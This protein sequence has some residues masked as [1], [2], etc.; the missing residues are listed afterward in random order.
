MKRGQGV[1]SV[2]L[3]LVMLSITG[4]F[5]SPSIE[6][7]FLTNSQVEEFL[8]QYPNAEVKIVHYTAEESSQLAT[9]M[10]DVC[11]K[12]LSSPKELYKAEISDQ[13][14]G[15]RVVAYLDAEE[16]VMECVRKFG[17]GEGPAS[18]IEGEEQPEQQE[19][20]L[21]N[22]ALPPEQVIQKPSCTTN[23]NCTGGKI[24]IDGSCSAL[25]EV[26]TPVTNCAKTC[27][28]NSVSFSTS[29]GESYTLKK[30]EGAYTYA[31]ALEWKVKALP[32]YCDT[33][34]PKV[35]LLLLKKNA[36]KIVEETYI[37]L[38][39]LETSDVITHPTI[40]RVKFTATVKAIEEVCS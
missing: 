24:C 37:T 12:Q 26:Y 6:T 18:I 10:A 25:A 30:G 38:G 35:A 1:I 2:F 15:L 5:F 16:K 21:P 34:E 36:G 39:L 27:N 4:C 9:E 22:Q 40:K 20:A 13:A 23:T 32:N 17:K 3:I 31:G 19:A 14:S 7:L 29:D 8:A 11:K 33:Q 28:Y